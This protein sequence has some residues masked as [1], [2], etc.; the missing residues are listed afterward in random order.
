MKY[1]YPHRDIFVL[2]SKMAKAQLVGNTDAH[3]KNF[4]MFHTRDGLR[5]T[6]QYDLVASAWYREYQSIALDINGIRNLA[7][8]KLDG[9]HL[10]GLGKGFGM[11]GEAVVAATQDL[12]KQLAAALTAIEK[13]SIGAPLM[14]KQLIEK[15]ERRWNG[16]FALTGQRLLKKQSKGGNASG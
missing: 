6:P 5:L 10:L 12:G 1:I 9:K 13:S 15:M 3:L 14:R 2:S 11:T 4:A 16:S 7:L 8:G